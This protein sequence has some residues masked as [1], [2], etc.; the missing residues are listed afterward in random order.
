MTCR[1][2]KHAIVE[3]NLDSRTTRRLLKQKFHQIQE[4]PPRVDGLIQEKRRGRNF[5]GIFR[6]TA[7][8]QQD[9]RVRKRIPDQARPTRSPEPKPTIKKVTPLLTSF[10]V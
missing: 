6:I 10:G 7:D 9:I 3:E 2:L 1:D 4:A 8:G 5:I